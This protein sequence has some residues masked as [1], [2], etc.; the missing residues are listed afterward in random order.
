MSTPD[1]EELVSTCS[2][3]KLYFIIE[4]LGGMI[5]RINHDVGHGRMPDSC[6]K[7]L[8]KLNEYIQ[9]AVGH[10]LRFGVEEPLRG[11]GAGNDNYWKWYR[12]WNAWHK[13]MS[14]DEWGE[15]AAAMNADEDLSELRPEGDWRS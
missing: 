13:V 9:T 2:E 14:D 12:W 1:F 15:I 6:L 10:T 8:P 11:N 3:A 7:D 4:E 5:W